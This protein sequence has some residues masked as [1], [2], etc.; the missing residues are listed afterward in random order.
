MARDVKKRQNWPELSNA[1][2]KS[3][4]SAIMDYHT[5]MNK[6]KEAID[7]GN[8]VGVRYIRAHEPLWNWISGK[9]RLYKL[10]DRELSKEKSSEEIIKALEA[11]IPVSPDTRPIFEKLAKK[12]S[13]SL[14]LAALGGTTYN[15]NEMH[16]IFS[17][18]AQEGFLDGIIRLLGARR[19]DTPNGMKIVEAALSAVA[20]SEDRAFD[21]IFENVKTVDFHR[22]DLTDVLE[23]VAATDST[24]KASV[25]CDLGVNVNYNEG[26][27]LKAA[28]FHGQSAMIDFLIDKGAR[29]D[30]YGEKILRDIISTGAKKEHID[31]FEARLRSNGSYVV[32]K[33]SDKRFSLAAPDT[34]SERQVLPDGG[35]LTVLF[36]FSTW[37]QMILMTGAAPVV[38]RFD[39]IS[40]QD[41]L[42]EMHS[43]LQTLGGDAP[44]PTSGK[45]LSKP[46]IE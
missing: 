36:N 16:D 34:L 17:I 35:F 9:E 41:V 43:K 28:A 38:I 22:I 26:A 42:S 19:L 44:A 11:S 20:Q 5:A 2:W 14:W 21:I 45:L 4:R 23:K 27:A 1:Q 13:E 31:A 24:Y 30:M 3:Y 46:R 29:I 18:A 33:E 39:D 12:K 40:R 37:Q 7:E 10:V 8:V 32:L 25:L 6:I 15:E